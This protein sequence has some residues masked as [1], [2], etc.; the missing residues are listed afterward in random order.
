[1]LP[2]SPTDNIR[3]LFVVIGHCNCQWW[4]C[5]CRISVVTVVLVGGQWGA[6]VVAIESL[7]GI[8]CQNFLLAA[9]IVDTD[10]VRSCF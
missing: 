7:V 5:Q 10:G 8:A 3:D 2:H 4:R 9:V 6:V 1:M